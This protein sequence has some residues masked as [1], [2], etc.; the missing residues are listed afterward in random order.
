[1]DDDES[2]ANDGDENEDDSSRRKKTKF[3]SYQH[4]N[5]LQLPIYKFVYKRNF[6]LIVIN[7]T[8]ATVKMFLL[9]NLAMLK[10]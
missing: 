6:I 1:M 8:H 9:L 4:L 3:K 2:V 5:H 10:P 7:L